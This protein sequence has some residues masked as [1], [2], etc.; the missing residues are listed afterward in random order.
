MITASTS[1]AIEAEPRSLNSPAS[2]S[3]IDL[4]NCSGGGFSTVSLPLTLVIDENSPDGG[5]IGISVP[6]HPIPEAAVSEADLARRGNVKVY[7]Q[8]DPGVSRIIKILPLVEADEDDGGRWTVKAQ[9]VRLRPFE[10]ESGVATLTRGVSDEAVK[11][12][13]ALVENKY[14]LV[15]RVLVE[16][17]HYLT[18]FAIEGSLRDWP[19]RSSDPTRTLPSWF[20]AASPKPRP[21]RHR[22]AY[23][24]LEIMRF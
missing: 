11:E 16:L 7:I 6:R 18:D 24:R 3:L 12:A 21:S 13:A 2:N 1:E 10:G 4:Q 8:L 20:C 5:R 17:E 23:S 19:P 9:F 14:V 15:L 22:L